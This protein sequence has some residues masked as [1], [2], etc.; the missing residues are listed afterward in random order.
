MESVEVVVYLAIA[1][2]LGGLVIAFV[3]GW[4]AGGAYDGVKSLFGAD[5]PKD[6]E[7]IESAQLSRAAVELWKACGLG[8]TA[9]N[10]TVYITDTGAIGKSLLFDGVKRYG[11]C[12]T[13]QYAA[14]SPGGCGAADDV[15]W[16]TA[17]TAGPTVLQLACNPASKKLV[18]S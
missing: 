5:E 15:D 17:A 7:K 13:L 1:V 16:M 18:V 11:L 3:A 2:I 10:K 12:K 9:M 14:Y 8:S 6:Y 4:D